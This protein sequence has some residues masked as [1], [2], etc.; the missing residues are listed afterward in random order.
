MLGQVIDTRFEE[1]VTFSIP[2]DISQQA[3]GLFAVQVKTQDGIAVR[4]VI[5]VD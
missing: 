2:M 4:E 5:K 1:G 3:A